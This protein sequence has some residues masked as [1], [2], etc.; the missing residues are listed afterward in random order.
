M[1]LIAVAI[2]FALILLPPYLIHGGYLLWLMD[3]GN[4]AYYGQQWLRG[5]LAYVDFW[6][7]RPP[8]IFLMNAVGLFLG[9][10]HPFGIA[11]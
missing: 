7:L 8:F 4:Y 9:N 10:G 1:Q 3:G 5:D 2:L 6:E 11:A